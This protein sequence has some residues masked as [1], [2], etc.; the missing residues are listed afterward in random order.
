MLNVIVN[1]TQV[2][3]GTQLAIVAPGAATSFDGSK[4][5]ID[6]S[7]VANYKEVTLTN[8]ELK[9]LRATPKELV[10][11]Q[12]AATVIEFVSAILRN[13]GGGECRIGERRQFGSQVHE[14]LRCCRL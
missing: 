6:L 9:A 7:A 13:S 1:G 8:A 12:G 2:G 3:S 11:A 10:A 4:S 5:T 14:W